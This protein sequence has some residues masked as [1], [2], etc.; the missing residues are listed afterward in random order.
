MFC[1]TRFKIKNEFDL[2]NVARFF[3]FNLFLKREIV[4]LKSELF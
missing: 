4:F 2:G 1:S 3:K